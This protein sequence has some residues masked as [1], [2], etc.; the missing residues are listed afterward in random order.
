MSSIRMSNETA[1][2]QRSWFT[3]A[4]FLFLLLWSGGFPAMKIGIDH[5]DPFFLLF[6]RY[7]FSVLLLAPAFLIIRPPLPANGRQWFHLVMTGILLQ[8]IYFSL[9]YTSVF[10]GISPGALALILSM[11]PILIGMFAPMVARETVTLLHW[12]GL[13]LGLG[14]AV[15]VIMS[16]STIE[17][18][19]TAGIIFA[20]LSLIS[21][22]AAT[23]YEKRFGTRQHPVTSNLVQYVVATA[24]MLPI[25]FFAGDM[26][27]DWAP[28]L[29]GVLFYLV[30]CNSIVSIS[31][32]MALIRRG[33]AS[34][35]SALFFLVPPVAAILSWI[36]I[37]EHM[38]L[39]AWGGMA[40]AALGVAI[41]SNP[42]MFT[43]S[44]PAE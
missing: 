17:A 25:A 26:H 1:S 28:P 16:R 42:G 11:Q 34:K 39:I 27:V 33:Q 29:I 40:V 23:L 32:L 22:T 19:S 35:V 3:L 13:A 10:M 14:G 9:C 7:F 41:V 38:P 30:V 8:V 2:G 21:M 44:K 24:C 31:L 37:G 12:L 43:R 6:L 5:A 15:V 18:H 20:I 36:I 4:P